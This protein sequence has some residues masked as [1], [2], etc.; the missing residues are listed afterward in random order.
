MESARERARAS[1]M[2]RAKPQNKN[3]RLS[4]MQGNT[5]HNN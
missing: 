4:N 1:A 5:Q 3:A 2:A